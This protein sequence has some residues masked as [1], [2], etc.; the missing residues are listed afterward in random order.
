V[1]YGVAFSTLGGGYTPSPKATWHERLRATALALPTIL[2]A[3]IIILSIYT[4]IATPSESAGVGFVA[5]LIITF[6]MGRMT[7]GKLRD[8][9]KRRWSPPL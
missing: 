9:T 3:T 4:G 6:V 1:I 8:A 7:W 2:L 5:A